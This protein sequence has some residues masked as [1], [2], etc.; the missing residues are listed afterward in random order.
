M[1]LADGGVKRPVYW[2]FI[3]HFSGGGKSWLFFRPFALSKPL[4]PPAA[5]LERPSQSVATTYLLRFAETSS[6][7][8]LLWNSKFVQW[9][10]P[11]THRRRVEREPQSWQKGKRKRKENLFYGSTILNFWRP[12]KHFNSILNAAEITR[13]KDIFCSN[14]PGAH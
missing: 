11:L 1:T 5:P 8:C 9:P 12:I 6:A 7:S 3:G 4:P 2:A 10:D 13:F 14:W